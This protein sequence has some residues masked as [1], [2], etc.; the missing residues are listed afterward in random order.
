M[1]IYIPK[2]IDVYNTHLKNLTKAYVDHNVEIIVG[3]ETFIYGSITPNVIHFHM[4]EGLISFMKYNTVL[5]FERMHYFKSKNVKFLYTAHDILPHWNITEINYIDFFF[6]FLK[7]IDLVVHHGHKSIE[8]HKNKFPLLENKIH[9][10]CPHGDYLNDMNIYHE[11][12]VKARNVLK[13][14]SEKK[15]ILVFGQLQFKNTVFAKQVFKLI[16]KEENTSFLIL[17]G[18]NPIFGKNGINNI[19]Y[20]LNNRFINQLRNHK[21]MLLGRFS[22]YDTYLLFKSADLIFL[23]H[24]NGLTSGLI[25]M[26]A[27]L[28][29]PFVYP[30]IGV[31]AEQSEFCYAEK[32]EPESELSA[33]RAIKKVFESGVR[34][35]DNSTWLRKNNWDIHVNIILKKI[36]SLFEW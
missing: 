8:I 24:K 28:G 16:N 27:T 10:V 18:V 3:Y 30:D 36:N 25:P 19:Y 21:K 6:H 5:F 33:F 14:P 15:I 34:E 1:V 2:D 23:P 7:Y 11:D 9:I 22:N 17:A 20:Q 29:V 35:F 12:K 4:V 31:F 13:L 26:A 32:Y